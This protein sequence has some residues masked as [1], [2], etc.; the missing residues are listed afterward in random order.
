M[1]QNDCG[2]VVGFN[3]LSVLNF[4]AYLKRTVKMT[5]IREGTFIKQTV[6]TTT[7]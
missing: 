3:N 2:F 4:D 7:P 6:L 1:F 5:V